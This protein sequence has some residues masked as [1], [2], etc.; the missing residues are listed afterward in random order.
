MTGLDGFSADVSGTEEAPPLP[1]PLG[2]WDPLGVR[3]SFGTYRG[4]ARLALAELEYR[5]GRLT[6]CTVLR[7]H[8]VR[9]LVFVCWGNICRSPYAELRAASFGL[10]A[11]SFGLST[12]SGL[13]AD[14]T[15]RRCA[16]AFGADLSS[17]R[18]C[19]LQDFRAREGDLLVFMEPRHLHRV[20]LMPA[21]EAFQKTLLGIWANPRRVHIHDPH[22]LSDAYWHSCLRTIDSGVAGLAR[23]MTAPPRHAR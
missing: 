18:A 9:R 21:F 23:K 3:P 2:G 20:E 6:A 13:P 14:A 16:A 4:L 8:E 17:H 5:F 15:G 22:R 10:P 19:A 7:W 12:E 11:A 1:L